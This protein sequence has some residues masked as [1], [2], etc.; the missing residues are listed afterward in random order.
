MTRTRVLV[1][2]GY[3]LALLLAP[4][5]LDSG[6]AHTLL[7]QVGIAII[8]C[9]A[10]NVLLGQGGM[11]SFGHAVYSGLGSF[12]TIRTLELVAAGEVGLPVSLLPLVG[13]LAGLSSAAV[14]GWLCTRHAG[15]PFAMVTLGLG[16]LVWSLALMLPETFGGEGGISANRVVGEP[17]AGIS[18]GPQIELYYLIAI[19]CGVCTALLYAFTGTPLARLLEAVRDNAERVACIGYDPRQVRHVAFMISGFFMG[20]AGGLSALNFEIA[21]VEM[22][23]TLRSGAYPLFTVLGGSTVFF[24]PIIGAVLMVVAGVLLSVWSRAWMLYLG[25]VFVVMVMRAPGGV[26]GLLLA[27]GRMLARGRLRCLLRPYAVLLAAA[28]PALLG[29]VLLVEMTYHLQADVLAGPTMSFFGLVVRPRQPLPWAAAVGLLALGLVL[30]RRAV[31]DFARAWRDVQAQIANR[32]Q[33]TAPGAV[34]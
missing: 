33:P 31:P 28:L 3:A 24:G 5:L 20:V 6:L 18:F 19:Y 27:N 8:G 12:L 26:A 9:L 21:T 4:L 23:G 22:L 10:Y 25:L 14:L 11:L 34:P 17:V 32:Q 29:L 13:G 2:G 16:E 1:W 15:T 30:L 7:A